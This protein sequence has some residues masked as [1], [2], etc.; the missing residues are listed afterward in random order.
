MDADAALVTFLEV[1][2][3]AD[4]DL[5]KAML[6]SCGNQCGYPLPLPYFEISSNPPPPPTQ[7]RERG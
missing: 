6:E 1:I 3:G 4:L 2:P 7:H 5:A